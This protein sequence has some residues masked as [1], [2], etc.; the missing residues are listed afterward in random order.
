MWTIICPSLE[1]LLLYNHLQ[2]NKY[3]KGCTGKKCDVT[4]ILDSLSPFVVENERTFLHWWS[5]M[6]EDKTDALVFYTNTNAL[7]IY[8]QVN[9]LFMYTC[10]LEMLH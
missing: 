3:K 8:V 5:W 9:A 2:N 1:N 4:Y 10:V 6:G 7:F